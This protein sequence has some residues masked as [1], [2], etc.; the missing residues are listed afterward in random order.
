[1]I[2]TSD[3]LVKDG[4]GIVARLLAIAI[5]LTMLGSILQG[6]T[7]QC[8]TYYTYTD[9]QAVTVSPEE[10]RADVQLEAPR[11]LQNPGK[12]YMKEPYLFINEAGEGVHIYDNSDKSNPVA[13]AFLQVP[14]SYDMAVLGNVLY[15]DSYTDLLAFDITELQDIRE[16][17]R[18]ED[19]FESR[20][21]HYYYRTQTNELVLTMPLFW[22]SVSTKLIATTIFTI[23][24]TERC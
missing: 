17:E 21:N 1:M 15:S 24:G 11:G 12:I 14:G 23:M 6:C 8:E 7:D 20:L 3:P 9:Y 4:F 22:L 19:V 10:F 16:I 2:K 5:I 18:V 13:K